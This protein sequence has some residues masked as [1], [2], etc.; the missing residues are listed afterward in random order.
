MNR[1]ERLALAAISALFVRPPLA[2]A[3]P[4]RDLPNFHAVAPGIWRGAAPSA[5][6]LKSL[7]E[8]GVKTVID[9]RIEKKGQ[10]E[11]AASAKAL[12]L[13]RVRI[14]MGREAPTERQVT[15]F[16]AEMK[17]AGAAPVFVHC[18]HGADRTGAMIG[19]WRATRQ[20]WPFD[21]T[22]AEMRKY[23]FKP[24]LTELKGS[25]EKRSRK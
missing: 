3:G 17:G 13:R 25:V 22:Y 16:L 7:K 18:Q 9:L 2:L 15:Q 24:Y 19:I 11:E 21:K 14:P 1:L 8:R 4:N 6:G 23:G 12:G 10:S 20:G 5:A